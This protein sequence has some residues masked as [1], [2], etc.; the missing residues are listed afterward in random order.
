MNLFR[1]SCETVG[2]CGNQLVTLLLNATRASEWNASSTLAGCLDLCRCRRW[3]AVLSSPAVPRE[4]LRD[5]GKR[6]SSSTQY[7]VVE[8]LIPSGSIPYRKPEASSRLSRAL[9]PAGPLVGL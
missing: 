7:R 2:A 3:R 8:E 6:P 5:K 4:P 1:E 9:R